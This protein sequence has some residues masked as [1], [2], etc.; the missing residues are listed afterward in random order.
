[1]AML[2]ALQASEVTGRYQAKNQEISRLLSMLAN[3]EQTSHSPHN[4]SA[5][6]KTNSE[7]T[8]LL[9]QLESTE[10]AL[11]AIRNK[12]KK[13]TQMNSKLRL[14]VEARKLKLVIADIKAQ[15]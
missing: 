15:L 11:N 9:K 1:M 5:T 13:E 7:K 8:A 14:N 4:P 10:A 2:I 6:D 12:L 3:D